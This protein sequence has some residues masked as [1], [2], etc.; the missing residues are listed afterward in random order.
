[1]ETTVARLEEILLRLLPVIGLIEKR[2]AAL[3]NRAPLEYFGTWE[4]GPTYQRGSACTLGGSLWIALR[5]TSERPNGPD[6]GW[7]LAVKSGDVAPRQTG[8]FPTQLR[9]RSLNGR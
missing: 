9:T 7:K 2:L 1:M 6:S 5:E 3:E 4:A 8:R